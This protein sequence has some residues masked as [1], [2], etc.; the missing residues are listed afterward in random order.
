MDPNSSTR[1]AEF[2]AG[3]TAALRRW[4][5]L[6]AAVEG[7]WG[8]PAS[9]SIAEDLRTNIFEKYRFSAGISTSKLPMEPEDLEDAIAEYMEEEFSCI[10]EDD[11]PR[12]VA[13]IVCEMYMKCAS[14]DFTMCREMVTVA[15]SEEVTRSKEKVVVQGDDDMDDDNDDED[16]KCDDGKD[17]SMKEYAS[18]SLFGG[19]DRKKPSKDI[20]PPRQLGEAQEEVQ[21]TEMDEDGF[22]PVT[23]RSRRSNKGQRPGVNC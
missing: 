1:E 21:E 7:E 20:P 11:S 3:V 12:F 14:D 4:S 22:A 5:A 23:R 10:L 19:D 2:Q 18:G 6:R 15:Q 9:K 8:G 13:A 16:M 17:D